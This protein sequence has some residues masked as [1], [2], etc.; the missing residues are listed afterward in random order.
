[1]ANIQAKPTTCFFIAVSSRIDMATLRDH[2]IQRE[3]TA[4]PASRKVISTE[5]RSPATDH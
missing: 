1:M 5:Y 2:T 3:V 4:A